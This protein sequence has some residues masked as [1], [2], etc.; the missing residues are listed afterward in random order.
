MVRYLVLQPRMME[1]L[2]GDNQDGRL[3]DEDRAKLVDLFPCEREQA[4]LV[5][6]AYV[7]YACKTVDSAM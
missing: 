7:L 3:Y 2:V 1:W 4:A 5:A 6:L